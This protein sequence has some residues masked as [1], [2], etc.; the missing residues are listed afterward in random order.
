MPHGGYEGTGAWR[1]PAAVLSCAAA[2]CVE[3]SDFQ[4][5]PRA[6]VRAGRRFDRRRPGFDREMTVSDPTQAA[7]L[8]ASRAII[9]LSN[10]DWLANGRIASPFRYR[11][12]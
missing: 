3:S 4:V 8:C 9:W 6:S 1:Q 7:G 11:G 10:I 2:A 5:I 12:G